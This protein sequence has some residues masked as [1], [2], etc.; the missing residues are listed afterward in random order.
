MAVSMIEIAESLRALSAELSIAAAEVNGA[1]ARSPL[2][3]DGTERARIGQILRAAKVIQVLRQRRT[4]Y[5]PQN[6]FGEP[7]WDMLLDLFVARET[8]KDITISA[9]CIASQVP[10]AT[11]LRYISK[12]EQRG[13]LIRQPDTRDSRCTLVRISDAAADAMRS[14]LAMVTTRMVVIA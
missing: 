6:M 5:F 14:W 7:G 3:S 11:A 4:D 8:K 13:D 12:L 10:Q 9:L 1:P 2:I